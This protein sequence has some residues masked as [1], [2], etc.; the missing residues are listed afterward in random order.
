[1]V[2]Y[3]GTNERTNEVPYAGARGQKTMPAWSRRF[4]GATA[5]RLSHHAQRARLEEEG[6]EQQQQEGRQGEE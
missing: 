1:M 4:A 6:E 5:R 3:G 2:N